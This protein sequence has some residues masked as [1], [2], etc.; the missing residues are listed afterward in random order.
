M[1]DRDQ[2]LE[3]LD[4]F[5]TCIMT[6]FT[7]DG[8]PHGRPM[9][10][11][12]RDGDTLRFVTAVDA[13]KV[14]EVAAGDPVVLTFQSSTR[15]VA[16]TGSA[17]VHQDRGAVADLWSEPMRAWFPDGPDDPQL[18]VMDVD[19]ESGEWWDV[20]GTDL[21]S[22]AFGVAKSVVTRQP[23]DTDREGDHGEVR[24]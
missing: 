5:D 10:V 19:L 2:F 6:T 17:R 9:H 4:E 16:A 1:S 8:T 24:L 12:E 22:F 14:K 3:V 18:C 23:I 7:R 13:A 11:A 21:A 15:W 20:S